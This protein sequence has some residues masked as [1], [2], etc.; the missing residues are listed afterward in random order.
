MRAKEFIYEA[1]LDP[2][3]WGQT[4]IGTDVDYFG[5][6]VKMRPSTFLKLAAPLTSGAKNPEVEKHMQ[7]GGKIAYPWL[8]IRDPAEW[9]TKQDFS[10]PAQVVGHEGRNRMKTWIKLKGDDPIQVNLFLKN[11]NRRRYITDEMIDALSKGLFAE[12]SS[13]FIKGPLFDPT[14]ALE[15]MVSAAGVGHSWTGDAPYRHLVELDDLE[16]GWKDWVAAGALGAAALAGQGDVQAKQI[17]NTPGIHQQHIKPATKSPS[18]ELIKQ[19]QQNKVTKAATPT[20]DPQAEKLLFQTAVKSGLR[21]D[22]LAQFMAQAKHESWNY[23][24][25]Q[26]KPVGDANKYFAKKYDPAYAPKTAKILG[27]KHK[28]DGAKYHGRG[29]IQLTGRDNY[30]MASD[31]LGIDLLDHPELAEKPEVA[32]QIAVWY[33]NT[34]VKPNIKNFGD[35]VEVTKKINNAMFGLED[36]MANFLDYKKRL[37]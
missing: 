29:F 28:G 8:D 17:P 4:P 3:G 5:L 18:Q 6:R 31:A 34:R 32:A 21:G 12:K 23:G 19:V 25:L 33:W 35:T 7:G 15:E 10:K 16:E 13:S 36:R 11:A 26:E 30:R 2:L 20:Q 9:E 1:E 14:T 27:N 22:E 24:R 37:A